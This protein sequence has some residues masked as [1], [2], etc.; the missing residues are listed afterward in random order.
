[1]DQGYIINSRK[2]LCFLIGSFFKVDPELPFMD[3]SDSFLMPQV[4]I[5][6][7][8]QELVNQVM[9]VGKLIFQETGVMISAAH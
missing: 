4:L 6:T 5:F 9:N 8:T 2:T 1:M 3:P 7:P